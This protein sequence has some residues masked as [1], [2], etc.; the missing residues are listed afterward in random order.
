MAALFCTDLEATP[1]EIRPWVVMRWSLAITCEETRAHLGF[2][3]PR[4]WSDQAIARTTPVL[5]GLFSVVTLLALQWRQSDPLP[6]SATAWYH[7]VEPT[8]ADCL[9]LVRQHLWRARYV[10]NSTP[11]AE[12]RQFPPEGFDLLI[13]GLPL[14]A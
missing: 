9:A 3:T 6:V 10:V 11:A 8:F 2:E 13:F 4:Q 1:V 14:A 5:L 12:S 7:Q